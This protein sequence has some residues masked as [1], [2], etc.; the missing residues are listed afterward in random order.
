MDIFN[1]FKWFNRHRHTLNIIAIPSLLV[2]VLGV[3]VFVYLTGGIK[4]VY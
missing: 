3:G 4:Y 1:I 2:M